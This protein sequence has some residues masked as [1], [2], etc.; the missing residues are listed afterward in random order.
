MQTLKITAV[1]ER[2]RQRTLKALEEA[3]RVDVGIL[4]DPELATIGA[5][6]EYGWQQRVT[7]NQAR[8]F[9]RH[10]IPHPP[11]A[12]AVL[13][14]PPRPF[15]GSTV[16]AES[17][18]W[19]YVYG[20]ALKMYGI[21]HAPNALIAVGIK[22]AE[23]IKDTLINGGTREE[24]FERR[25]TLT[26]ELYKRQAEGHNTDGTGNIEGDKPLVKT[27]ALLNSIG[28]QLA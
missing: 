20:K 18:N 15:I 2:V 7:P 13:T 8:W 27:G 3:T 4:D 14:L 17:K 22:A 5:W 11:T 6:Q 23:D 19:G 21:D 28:Y 12:G 9:Q 26:Q 24:K 25:S 1:C 16:R 10:R